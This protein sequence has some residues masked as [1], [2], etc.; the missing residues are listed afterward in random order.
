MTDPQAAA[1]ERPLPELPEE[2]GQWYEYQDAFD[3]S[4]TVVSYC[5][6]PDRTPLH[7]IEL[8]TADQ[9]REYV[10]ADRRAAVSSA[11]ADRAMVQV[12][13]D[14][15]LWLMG[16]GADSFTPDREGAFW[17]R[18]AFNERAGLDYV[19]IWKQALKERNMDRG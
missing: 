17:W 8:F 4:Q 13:R 11:S 16:A 1:Q 2:Q 3:Q 14:A 5:L 19:A 15:Y 12:P 6:V 18:G 9:M 7:V 10:L